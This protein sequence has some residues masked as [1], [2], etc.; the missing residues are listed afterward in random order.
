[1]NNAPPTD[2]IADQPT[3]PFDTGREAP[4]A[5]E[6]RRSSRVAVAR[7]GGPVED[8]W[9]PVKVADYERYVDAQKAVDR[10]S[11]EG[12][13]LSGVTIVWSGLRHSEHVTGRRT[14]ASAA[15]SGLVTGAWFGAILGLLIS[16]F[17]T[18]DE[19]VVAMMLVYAAVGAIAVA[20]YEAVQHWARR[21]TRDFST[22]GRLDAERYEVWVERATLVRA[23]ELLQVTST[24]P[25]DPE[26][27][28]ASEEVGS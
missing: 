24:R 3:D 11:D 1:M 2:T 12:F 21:G 16:A 23:Q 8:D 15:A 19:S 27:S 25:M 20:S 28:G 4:E 5:P 13:P 22:T 14:V 17:A 26:P 18:A 10:L 9:Q 6:D 7:P